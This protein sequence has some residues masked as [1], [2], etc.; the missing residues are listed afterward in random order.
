MVFLRCGSNAYHSAIRRQNKFMWIPGISDRN[1]KVEGKIILLLKTK[2][3]KPKTHQ[4]QNVLIIKFQGSLELRRKLGCLTG[5]SENNLK[6]CAAK[7]LQ[8][9]IPIV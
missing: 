5:G 3:Y 9:S 2:F 7:G 4:G 6:L 1:I 8:N